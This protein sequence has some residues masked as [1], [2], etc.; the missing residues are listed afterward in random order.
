MRIEIYFKDIMRIIKIL[1]LGTDT[2]NETLQ[3]INSIVEFCSTPKQIYLI[4]TGLFDRGG[5]ELFED[6]VVF[7][8]NEN[9]QIKWDWENARYFLK[10]L[11]TGR[12]H[13]ATKNVL[14]KSM[15]ICIKTPKEQI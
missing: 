4:S 10:S 11:T 13:D 6:S 7:V 3:K 8:N 2:Q 12:R 14:K 5:V 9:F 1:E 15:F